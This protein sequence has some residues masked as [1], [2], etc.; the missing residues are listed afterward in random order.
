MGGSEEDMLERAMDA[1]A[2][3]QLSKATNVAPHLIMHGDCDW[4]VPPEISVQYYEALVEAGY[5]NQTD[6]YLIKGAAHGTPEFFQPQVREIAKN[7]SGSI[8]DKVSDT[9][10]S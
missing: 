8:W 3:Y 4:L 6:L 5:E 9:G 10:I 7:F 1:S 2:I